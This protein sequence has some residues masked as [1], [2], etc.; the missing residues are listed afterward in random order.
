MS[1]TH[2]ISALAAALG[3]VAVACWLVT[4]AFPLVAADSVT[5]SPGVT[6]DLNGATLLHRAALVYPEVSRR[7]G[8]QGTVVVQVKL[9]GSGNVADAQVM[10]GPEALRRAAL[11]SVLTWHFS[12]QM[13]GAMSQVK[14]GFAAPGGTAPAMQPPSVPLPGPAATVDRPIKSLNVVGLSDEA[15]ADLLGRLPVHEGDT[16]SAESLRQL[17]KTVKSFDEHLAVTAVP[18]NGD[19]NILIALAP[20]TPPA[21]TRTASGRLRIGGNIQAL[22]LI[23]QP[24][25]T[26]PVEAKQARVQGQV[27]LDAIIGKD[28]TVQNLTVISGHPL[29]VAAALGAVRQWVYQP[30]L[31]NGNPTEVETEIDVNFTLAQ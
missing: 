4:G 21:V 1:K 20:A 26:Y 30:T 17:V 9:D 7:E 15:R 3:T 10:S 16:L 24:K 6:V 11:E 28:G 12:Q 29:L 23:T 27:Q 8:I 5:D 2:L 14:I 31:L 22:K 13:A 18:S 25:P 19:A